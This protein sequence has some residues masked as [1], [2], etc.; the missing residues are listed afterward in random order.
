MCCVAEVVIQLNAVFSPLQGEIEI[1]NLG[2]QQVE[3][4]LEASEVD[5]GKEAGAQRQKGR[6]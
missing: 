3:Q 6:P 1:K 4:K 5:C 2:A